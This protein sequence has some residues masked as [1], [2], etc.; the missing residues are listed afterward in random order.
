MLNPAWQPAQEHAERLLHISH[1]FLSDN[2]APAPRMPEAE[3]LQLPV[4]LALSDDSSQQQE[5]D[6]L[7]RA[8]TRQLN[9][10]VSTPELTERVERDWNLQTCTHPSELPESIF[11]IVMIDATLEATRIAYGLLKQISPRVIT[12][13]GVIYR[14]GD[15]LAAARRCYRRLAVGALRFLDLPLVN[16]GWLPNPGPH[17]AASLA[18]ASQVIQSHGR[19]RAQQEPTRGEAMQ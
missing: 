3:T 6:Y 14:A 7:L 15:D 1:H 13:V 17:F 16:L 12:H 4:L 11:A 5:P 10:P 2:A 9:L 18:H 19:E 8:L